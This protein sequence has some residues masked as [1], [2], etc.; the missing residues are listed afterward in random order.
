MASWVSSVR[1]ENHAF[2]DT[3]T[4]NYIAV[5]CLEFGCITA[6]GDISKQALLVNEDYLDKRSDAVLRNTM[7]W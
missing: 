1:R 3:G 5:F 4:A 2:R 6:G 7:L